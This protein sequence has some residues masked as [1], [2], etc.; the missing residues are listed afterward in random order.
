MTYLVTILGPLAPLSNQTWKE[1]IY[2][3]E[4]NSQTRPRLL[5]WE[6]R[7]RHPE[8]QSSDLQLEIFDSRL[9]DKL[10][11]Q[12]RYGAAS[13]WKVPMHVLILQLSGGK[14]S[15]GADTLTSDILPPRLASRSAGTPVNMGRCTSPRGLSGG[16]SLLF[17]SQGTLTQV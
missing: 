13:G 9:N 1:C 7:G 6:G 3:A 8:P 14:V 2:S 10:V 4:A 5:I 16:S 15:G 11:Q 12:L 17:I